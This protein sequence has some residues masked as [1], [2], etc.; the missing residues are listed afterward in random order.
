MAG[1]SFE[2]SAPF[3]PYGVYVCG[4]LYVHVSVFVCMVYACVEH[5][6]GYRSSCANLENRDRGQVPSSIIL[7]LIFEIKSLI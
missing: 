7:H 2:F 1:S 6:C 3:S 4:V 5:M